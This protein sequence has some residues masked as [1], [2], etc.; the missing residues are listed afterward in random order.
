MK[1]DTH[2]PIPIPL[3]QRWRDAR[4]R[5]VPV[6]IFAGAITTL[7]MLWKNYV[8]AP[9]L[10]GQAEAVET[11]VSS[12]RPGMLAELNVARFQKV[13]AGEAVGQVL[14]T[15][16]RILASSLAVIQADIEMLRSGMEPIWVQQRTAMDYGRLRLDWMRQRAQ[17][18][19]AR[20][21]LQLAGTEFHRTEELFR[22][23]IVSERVFDQAKAAQERLQREVDELGQLVEQ[24]ARNFQDLQTTNMLDL[25]KVSDQPLRT[26]IAAQEAKLRLTEAELSPIALRAPVD[27]MVTLIHHHAGEAVT[28]GEPIVGIAALNSVRIIGYLRPPLLDEPKVGRQ[29]EV[30][31][32][33]PHRQMGRAA[34]TAVGTQFESITPQLL[35]PMKLAQLELGLPV[36]ISMPANV[37]LRPGELVDV[38]LKR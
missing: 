19:T 34:I 13:K 27:G 38:T 8:A 9:T 33:G 23:K 1:S 24:Q 22:D 5:V 28:A 36:S 3:E 14:V 6:V 15:D 4:L 18:A 10:V 12:Y 11:S 7:G 17:L 2:S 32:R 21:N 30:A 25:S 20:V 35:G 16:P 37:R 29:V 26:A 31:T